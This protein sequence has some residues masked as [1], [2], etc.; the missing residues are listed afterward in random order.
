MKQ[1]I[2]LYFDTKLSDLLHYKLSDLEWEILEGLEAVLL[3]SLLLDPGPGTSAHLND[4]F[5]TLFSRA[6]HPSQR[7]SCRVPFL[8]LRCS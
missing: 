5:L 8:I 6:C 1:A 3:V 7:L 2:D 4:R